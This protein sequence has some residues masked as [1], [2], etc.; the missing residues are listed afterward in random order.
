[1]G[2]AGGVI[3]AKEALR[4]QKVQPPYV[5]PKAVFEISMVEDVGQLEGVSAVARSDAGA[6]LLSKQEIAN[7]MWDQFY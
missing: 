1:M 6:E 4:H 5:P 2:K 7:P 3:C